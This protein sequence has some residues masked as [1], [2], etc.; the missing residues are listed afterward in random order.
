[1]QVLKSINQKKH[2][3]ESD[4]SETIIKIK[5]IL[6]RLNIEVKEEW[7]DESSI[8][9]WALR[10]TLK[11]SNYGSNGKG[12]TKE[13]ALASAYAELLERYQNDLLGDLDV[14]T[15]DTKYNFKIYYDE[16]MMTAEEIIN[17]NNEYIKM[18][19]KKRGLE[20]STLEEKA[21][22]IKH[23]QK[24]DYLYYG[25]ENQY[26]TIP[27]YS[28]KYDKV[29]YL[30]RNIY[31][32]SYG[33]NGMSAGNTFEEAVV[34]AISEIVERYVQKRVIEEKITL[35]DIP[36]YYIKKH[37]Y[38]YDMLEKLRENTKFSYYLKDASLGGKFPV[39]ALVILE[40]NT[41]NYGIKFGCHPHFG[42]AMERTFTEAAQGQDIYDYSK[43]SK[44]DF[45][46][47]RVFEKINIYNTFKIGKGQYPYQLFGENPTFKFVEMKDVS[48][49]SNKEILSYYQENI[50]QSGYDLLIRNVSY[51]DFPS[52]HVI[53]PGISE[54]FDADD[55]RCKLYN[56]RYYVNYLLKH[57]KEIKKE[58]VKL[59]I[60]IL[61]YFISSQMEST[62]DTYYN[63]CDSSEL[64]CAKYG[65]GT[66]Y[67]IAM[68]YVILGNYN[69][70]IRMIQ[71]I[72]TILEDKN[73]GIDVSKNDLEFYRAVYYYLSCIDT[74][75]SIDD[76]RNYMM[77]IFDK[78][79]CEKIFK[80]F[81]DNEEVII[82]QYPSIDDNNEDVILN[83]NN[84]IILETREI[85]KGEQ[86]K[87]RIL[88]YDIRN[89]I[90]SQ[91]GLV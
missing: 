25:K 56:T 27:F 34:Q 6:S 9:T 54:M 50:V 40:N 12:V 18:Y 51:L 55:I 38:I 30:P 70:A 89:M 19:F 26:L 77:L 41:G 13:L 1:M 53:I 66:S 84:K 69:S 28:C 44:I 62:I 2:F 82:K 20:N 16:K 33:S 32:L 83:E 17:E 31:R 52:V 87:N 11:N 15:Y 21:E 29:T 60:T 3:K 48:N 57:P 80:I 72:I 64:P 7:Q 47:K 81:K 4:P 73:I 42:I 90:K 88:Q 61:N 74:I 14:T 86:L 35:P 75:D 23:I 71:I 65:L 78:E 39:A 59:I 76:I 49:Y 68:C 43:R 46:N 79:I 91:E 5:Q 8:G 10:V 24:L 45:E 37:P 85:L 22:Q 63:W 67:L 36:D 58:N